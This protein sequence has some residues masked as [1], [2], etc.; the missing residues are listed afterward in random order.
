[1]AVARLSW[2]QNGS[3]EA[4]IEIKRAGPVNLS[5]QKDKNSNRDV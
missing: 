5:Q 4:G 2:L 1:M 3:P